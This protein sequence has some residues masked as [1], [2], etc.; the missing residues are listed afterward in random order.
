MLLELF[1]LIERIS[2]RGFRYSNQEMNRGDFEYITSDHLVL[3]K[4]MDKKPVFMLSNF[5]NSTSYGTVQR[6][7]KDC[8]TIMV[9]CPASIIDYNRFM[10]GVD[11]ADQ[12]KES[13]AL[14]RK[15][16]RW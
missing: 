6:T 10:R 7:E 15:S 3:H 14:D 5:H 1:V 11:R 8:S 2:Q 16:R 9:T 13:Y 4:W 12:R